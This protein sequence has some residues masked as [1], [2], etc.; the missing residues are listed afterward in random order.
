MRHVARRIV[1]WS[2][3]LM[4]GVV[5]LGVTGGSPAYA[6]TLTQIDNTGSHKCVT[7]VNGTG[8]VQLPCTNITGQNWIFL[9]TPGGIRQIENLDTG[10]CMLITN[11]ANGAPVVLSSCGSGNQGLFWSFTDLNPPFPVGRRFILKSATANFCLDL[12]HGEVQDWVPMQV[13]GCNSNTN[14]QK[15]DVGS[16]TVGGGP[17]TND[18]E[19]LSK[20]LDVNQASN[21]NG[22][23][24][25]L[26]HCN[27]TNAQ[28]WT[29]PSDGFTGPL[30]AL[31]KCLDQIGRA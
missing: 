10:L 15:W 5:G 1:I 19:G 14:N 16:V 6:D 3:A 13:W 8:L 23:Q 28:V 27:Q 4:L 12:E 25:Q 26:Y 11:F 22:T 2:T 18:V 9:G 7:A 24:I 29:V 31:G 17:T 20:C 21:A 30:R